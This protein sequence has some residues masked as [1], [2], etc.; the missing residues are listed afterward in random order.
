[1]GYYILKKYKLILIA[2]VLQYHKQACI[3]REYFD[4]FPL[5]G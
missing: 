2:L 1:M 5:I 4:N 3:I